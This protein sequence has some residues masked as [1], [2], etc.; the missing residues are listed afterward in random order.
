MT[1]VI[2]GV[3]MEVPKMIKCFVKKDGK[4]LKRLGAGKLYPYVL[5]WGGM[6]MDP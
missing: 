5:I 1:T 3:E 6:K 2:M 4:R